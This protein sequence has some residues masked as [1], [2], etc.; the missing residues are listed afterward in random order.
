MLMSANANLVENSREEKIGGSLF[1]RSIWYV[2]LPTRRRGLISHK[3]I[4]LRLMRMKTTNP[5]SI[6]SS[7]K[8][9]DRK[10]LAGFQVVF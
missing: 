6:L 1:L 8:V 3:T 9:K 7:S 5:S 4:T 10:Y 2:Y